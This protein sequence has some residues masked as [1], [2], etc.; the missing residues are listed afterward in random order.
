M[1]PRKSS[2][3]A[4]ADAAKAVEAK[5]KVD[6]KPK[7]NTAAK[8]SSSSTKKTATANDTSVKQTGKGDATTKA[9]TTA[10]AEEPKTRAVKSATGAKRGRPKK[11]D[12]SAPAKPAPKKRKAETEEARETKKTKTKDDHKVKAPVR[13]GGRKV[14]VNPPRFV[15]ELNVF[16]CG[17]G[18]AG[19]LGL[20]ASK[21]A[22]DVKRPRFNE[23]LS[24]MGVV[25]IATGGMHCVALTKDNNILTWGVNDNGALGRDTSNAEVKLRDV[26][27]ETGS[28]SDSDLDSDSGLN[29]LEATPT[30]ISMEHFPE[31]TVF[32]DVAAGDSCSL[33]LTDEGLVF[34]WGNFRKNEGVLGFTKD[35]ETA[36][37]PIHIDGLKKITQIACGTNHVLALDNSNQVWAWGNGQQNQLG[38]RLTER[39]MHTSLVPTRVGFTDSTVKKHSKKMTQVACGDYHG[40]AIGTDGHVW[41]WGVN[42]YGETGHPEGAGS[43]NATV[44]TA[45]I[46]QSLEGRN[47]MSIK[48]GS[49]HN[50]AVTENGECLVWGR[51]DGSQ[52]GIPLD[53]LGNNGVLKDPNGRPKVLTEPAVVPGLKNVAMATCG[54]E[55]SIAITDNG[56]AY[57]WGFSATYQ[58]GLGTDDDIDTPTLIENTAV[59]DKDLIWA[60]CGGQFSMLASVSGGAGDTHDQTATAA[61]ASSA[62]NGALV[63]PATGTFN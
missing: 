20:G 11:E 53:Q 55:H 46:I 44:P 61:S 57:S 6:N 35:V 9:K 30:A 19:E 52:L 48:G 59:R 13:R 24:S 3:I 40:F 10:K 47:I 32:V 21:K 26:D 18:S 37:F 4:N 33:A 1:A 28:D 15:D 51:C 43:D 56:K 49:H 5:N 23:A 50:V 36:R 16:V 34:G 25:K 41:S 31:D 39:S 63:A 8:R 58:T 45:T 12:A 42:N 62:T 17:E 54:P 7:A 2:R 60:G 27:D 38:R 14:V 22:I 29:E